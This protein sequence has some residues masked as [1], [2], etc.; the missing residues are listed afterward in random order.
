MNSCYC[1]KRQ[2]HIDCKSAVYCPVVPPSIHAH[3]Q[4]SEF[5]HIGSV[6]CQKD[7]L[8]IHSSSHNEMYS[9]LH[10]WPKSQVSLVTWQPYCTIAIAY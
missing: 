4:L 7:W 8:D 5:L 2:G 1:Q 9:L 10:I 6:W 3:M